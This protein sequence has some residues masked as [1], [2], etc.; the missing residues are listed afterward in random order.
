MDAEARRLGD[1]MVRLTRKHVGSKRW[2][3]LQPGSEFVA[4]DFSRA[5]H[6]RI[7]ACKWL[8]DP[9][10]AQWAESRS[11]SR[12]YGDERCTPWPHGTD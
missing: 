2:N 4:L 9:V 11:G 7:T 1:P 12:T 6:R 10:P 8:N 5:L 3:R